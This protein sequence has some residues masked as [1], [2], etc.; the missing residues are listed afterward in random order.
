MGATRINQFRVSFPYYLTGSDAA[1][2][3]MT[4]EAV[5]QFSDDPADMKDGDCAHITGVAFGTAH[6]KFNDLPA[7][8]RKAIEARAISEAYDQIEKVE[9]I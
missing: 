3:E 7:D 9:Y 6:L 1:E 4:V 8:M 5:I 2:F